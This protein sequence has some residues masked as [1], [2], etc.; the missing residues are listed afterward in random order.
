LQHFDRPLIGAVIRGLEIHS[1]SRGRVSISQI[2]QVFPMADRAG[3]NFF[4]SYGKSISVLETFDPSA[5]LIA[6]SANTFHN[7]QRRLA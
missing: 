3:S 5:N 1:A 6:S 2:T 7:Q 4:R